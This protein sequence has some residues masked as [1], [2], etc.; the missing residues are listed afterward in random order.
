MRNLGKLHCSPKKLLATFLKKKSYGPAKFF[1][2]TEITKMKNP[3][4]NNTKLS[5]TT[6]LE[7][8]FSWMWWDLHI[9][10]EFPP[11]NFVFAKN[12]TLGLTWNICQRS[13]Y[14][15]RNLN[16]GYVFIAYSIIFMYR[17]Y[18][19]KFNNHISFLATTYICIMY[20]PAHLE[21]GK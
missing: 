20:H 1:F 4:C 15:L 6:H 17:Y 18:S 3:G 10:K 13:G 8:R 2:K 11:W 14:V 5:R 7:S 21:E 9:L 19:A 16:I 12:N